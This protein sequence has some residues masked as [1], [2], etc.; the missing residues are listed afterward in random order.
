MVFLILSVI[1]STPNF[2]LNPFFTK[3]TPFMKKPFRLL[4]F[5][6]FFAFL[7]IG[8]A[9]KKEANKVKITVQAT[10]GKGQNMLVATTNIFNFETDTLAAAK[11]DSAGNAVLEFTLSKPSFAYFQIGQRYG[12]L[13]L[14]PDDDLQIALDLSSPNSKAIYKGKGAETAN[15]LLESNLIR[16]KF[17]MAG[18]KSFLDL[19]SEAF[20]SR[21]DSLD[22]AYSS[23]HRTYTDSIKI[24][25]AISILFEKQNRM[26]LLYRKQ[27]HAL[28]NYGNVK[29]PARL[30]NVDNEIPF[31]TTLLNARSGV[32]SMVLNFYLRSNFEFALFE[33]KTKEQ[34][35]LLSEQSPTIIDQEIRKG[36]YPKSIMDFLIAKNVDNQLGLMGLNAVT[37]SLFQNFKKDFTT[38]PYL[39]FLEKR[40]DSWLALSKGKPALDFVGTTPEGKKIALNDLKGK[41]VYVDVWATWCGPC[42]EEIAYGKKIKPQFEGNDEVVFLY[43]SVDRD[44]EAWKKYL[45]KDS[46]FKGLHI[47]LIEEQYISLIKAYQMWG[48]PQFMLID[49]AGKIVSVKAPR[50]SSGKVAEEI[51]K[52]LKSK[53]V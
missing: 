25:K 32:Y 53:S 34:I 35:K 39:F 51:Q 49:Q 31:D 27:N 12:T 47:N 20:L 10:G 48:I 18:G 1:N 52:L 11:F 23:F 40:Y 43:V 44:V 2:P 17:E 37:D 5:A 26:D 50:P 6:G 46:K 24:S 19:D 14:N 22:N 7:F 4:G 13:Y 15:Y 38:S 8:C 3:I 16:D 41:V 36:N 33:G 21:L 9:P 45:K 30:K 29:L 42:V 28:A